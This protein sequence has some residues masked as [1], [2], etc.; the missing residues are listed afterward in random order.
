MDFGNES[1]YIAK[2]FKSDYGK[3]PEEIS[4]L[5]IPD[6]GQSSECSLE[7]GLFG[8]KNPTMQSTSTPTA[9]APS[10]P[11]APVPKTPTPTVQPMKA[12]T[13]ALSQRLQARS[14]PAVQAATQRP[15]NQ[16]I[17]F[18]DRMPSNYT[19]EQRAQ[20][21]HHVANGVE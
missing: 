6:Y 20:A 7:K 18:E 9:T 21:I 11:A 2:L 10:T 3:E 4:Q 8:K 12:P 14:H 5:F 16:G 17:E 1:E 19:A 13:G 15:N